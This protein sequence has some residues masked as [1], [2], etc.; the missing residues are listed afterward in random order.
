MKIALLDLNHTTLGIHTNTAPLGLGL[1]S[2]YVKNVIEED[3]E[4]KMFKVAAKAMDIFKSWTPDIVG[5]AQYCWNSEL[6]LFITMRLKKANPDCLVVAGGPNLEL[7][8]FRRKVF[9]KERD[10]IDICVEFDGEIP[11]AEIVKR[12]L[13]GESVAS[14]K[15]HPSAGTYSFELQSG[16]LIQGEQPPPRLTSLD[17]FG[18]IY[19]DGLF[20]EFLDDGFHPFVQTHRGCPYTCTFCHTSD[21]YYSKM[22]FQSPEIFKQDMDY[23]GKRFTGQSHVALYIANTNMGQ[24]KQDFEIGR[25]IRE[26]QKK[27]D[28]PRKIDVNSGKDPKKLLEM[29]SIVNFPAAIALQTNTPHVLQNIKRKNIPFDKYVAFQ[30]DLMSKSKDNSVTELIL[31]LPGETKETFLDTLRDVINSGVQSIVIYTM[32]NLKGT[33]MSS[34]ESSERYN[35]AIRHRIVPRQFSMIDGI[36]IM[37]TEEVVVATEDMSFNDYLSLRGLSFIVTTFFSSA[38][39]SPLK[40]FLLEYKMDIAEWIFSISERLPEY[41]ELYQNYKAFLKETEDELFLSR[42]ALI[43]FYHNPENFEALCSGRLGDNLLRK[44]K[45]LAL[46]ENYESCLKLAISVAREIIHDSFE[47]YKKVDVMID[48]LTSYLFTRNMKSFLLEKNYTYRKQFHLNYDIP[49]W[50]ENSD[51]GLLL[52]DFNSTCDYAVTFTDDTIKR[53][54]N[55]VEMNKDLILS[56]Q[57]LYR[58]GTI[59]EYWPQWARSDD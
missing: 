36:K 49:R 28:W 4:I 37:D 35:H 21:S 2:R 29:V 17:E 53:L 31:C 34:V 16:E 32:M 55:I 8:P 56:L 26:T 58:D 5:M 50:L 44:Y 52:E 7:S 20:D 6:N 25:I 51:V 33:P 3:V 24:F 1:I 30:K 45:L 18:A 14:V 47:D 39:L 13:S 54:E 11:F 15:S 9:L 42:D 19:T 41:H 57:I 43:A 12:C 46:S 27:Y 23:L 10:C 59:R 40:K 22:L 48:D 38:E